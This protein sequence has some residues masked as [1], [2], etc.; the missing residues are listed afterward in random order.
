MYTLRLC[1]V[2]V[3]R[4]TDSYATLRIPATK[5]FSEYVRRESLETTCQLFF[6][7]WEDAHACLMTEANRQLD[8]ARRALARAQGDHDRVKGM[9]K[10]EDA[11]P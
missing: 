6:H 5:Y 10:P 2:E 1:K 11:Q 4:L 9:K 7:T 8:R 3:I